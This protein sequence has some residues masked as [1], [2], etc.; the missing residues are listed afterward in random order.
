MYVP[1]SSTLYA[2]DSCAQ[3]RTT[4]VLNFLGTFEAGTSPLR[5]RRLSSYADIR[6]QS[7]TSR[8]NATIIWYFISVIYAVHHGV[9]GGLVQF[10]SVLISML[11]STIPVSII[12]ARFAMAVEPFWTP[13][14]YSAPIVSYIQ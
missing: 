5:G 9:D 13:E 10:P 14:Q 6:L 1:P 11:G 3:R 12:G 4:V 8:K 7:Q 2:E